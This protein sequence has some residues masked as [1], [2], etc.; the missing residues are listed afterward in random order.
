M[1]VCLL[2]L[3]S[4]WAGPTVD[5]DGAHLELPSG[6]VMTA[7]SATI[8]ATHQVNARGTRAQHGDLIITAEV[9]RWAVQDGRGVF[10]GDVRAVQGDLRFTC[11]RVEV[12]LDE[13]GSV[14]RAVASGP[15]QVRQGGRTAVGEGAVFSKGR[16]VLSGDAIVRDGLHEMK[17]AEIVFEVGQETIE[18]TACTMTVRSESKE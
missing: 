17:G 4:A 9:T 13:D 14:Q 18:C 3:S 5:V 1:I 2:W 8:D 10:E 11:A 12:Q 15:V 7:E 6:A 16:L